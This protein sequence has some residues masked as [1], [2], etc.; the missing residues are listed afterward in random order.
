MD[1]LDVDDDGDGILSEDEGLQDIDGDG[2]P[3]HLDEDSDGDGLTDLQEGTSDTDCDGIPEWADSVADDLCGERDSWRPDTIEW[4]GC[5][6]CASSGGSP[7]WW[8]W[9]GLLCVRRR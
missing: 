6:G 1:A 8:T 5:Q 7:F 4:D 3:N 9:V 2:V